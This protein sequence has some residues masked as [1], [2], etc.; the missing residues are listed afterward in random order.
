M[1]QGNVVDFTPLLDT[2]IYAQSDVLFVAQE[3][4]GFFPDPQ[5]PVKL[6]SVVVLDGDDQNIAFD[7]VFSNATIT[8]GTLNSG[9][10]ITDAD[11]AKIIGY[12]VIASTDINDTINSRLA[13]KNNINQMLKPNGSTSVWISGVLRGA[14]TPTYTAAGMKIKLGYESCA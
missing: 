1:A 3:L 4:T 12:V 11:A 6:M 13:A 9:V 5:T 14:G 7:L 2:N 8:L 10:T